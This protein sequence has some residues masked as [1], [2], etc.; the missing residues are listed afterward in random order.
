MENMLTATLP[1]RNDPWY[2]ICQRAMEDRRY[3]RVRDGIMR[4]NKTLSEGMGYFN[5]DGG[6]LFH[7]TRAQSVITA[8][9]TAITLAST[10]KLLHPG[11][12]TAVPTGYFTAGKKLRL[13]IWGTM[14]TI[15]TPGNIGIEL[16]VGSADAGGTLVASSA[17]AALIASQSNIPILIVAYLKCNGGAVEGAK[18]V[19]GYAR[20]ETAVA[21][22]T[23]ANQSAASPIPIATPA[24]VNIDNTLSTMGFNVQIK[25]SGST[26]ETFTTRDIT[27]ESLT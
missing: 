18:P 14:T 10:D 26:A 11:A 25:R 23:A 27:F 1:I 12:L 6:P 15:L 9:A 4:G 8:P 22:V 19:E 7:D 20:W 2:V 21:L 5:M 16:Y 24:A 13:T 3:E 17:A